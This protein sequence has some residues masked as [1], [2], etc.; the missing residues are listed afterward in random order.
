MQ[1][2]VIQA[3]G[4]LV[5]L[6]GARWIASMLRRIGKIRVAENAGRINHALLRSATTETSPTVGP[7]SPC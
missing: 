1:V 7:E 3:F 4:V 5:F 2:M 6:V